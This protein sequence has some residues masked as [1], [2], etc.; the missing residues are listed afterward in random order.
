MSDALGNVEYQYDQLSH[1]KAEIRTITGV[2]NPNASDG[3]FKLSYDYNLAGALKK[4]TDA[5]NMSIVYSYDSTGRINSVTGADTLYA[6]V[7]QYASSFSYRAWGA[8]KDFTDGTNQIIS[9]RYNA[10]LQTSQFS[11]GAMVQ[12]FDYFN[13]GRIKFLDNLQDGNFDRSFSY[14][15]QGRLIAAGSGGVARQDAGAVPYNQ[16]FGYDAFSN[17][18]AHS[19]STWNQFTGSDS[20]VYVNN[21]RN[22]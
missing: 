19:T 17:L 11:I 2:P 3:K 21:R 22:G 16:T 5:T 4:I 9:R 7:S 14:D 6:S 20:A 10:R 18:T 13:D 12:N 8:L 15:Q 1:L